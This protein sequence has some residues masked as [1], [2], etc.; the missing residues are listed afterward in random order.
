MTGK[1]FSNASYNKIYEAF[2]TSFPELVKDV[3]GFDKAGFDKELRMVCVNLKNGLHVFYG[4]MKNDDN[5]WEWC[6]YLDMSDKTKEALG[7]TEDEE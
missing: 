1:Q 2:E 5:E 3:V 7:I 4:T 6:A